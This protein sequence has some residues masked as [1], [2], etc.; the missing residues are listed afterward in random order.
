MRRVIVLIVLI[1][2]GLGLWN[3][4]REYGP[5]FNLG[6]NKSSP[7]LGDTSKVKVVT[8]ESVTVDAV[9]K[10]GPSVVTIAA[11]IAPQSG[12]SPLD[13]G[14]FRIF[15]IQPPDQS[16][17]PV[18]QPQSIGSGFIVSADGLI[19][20]NKHVVSDTSGKYQV[21]TASD[22]KYDVQKI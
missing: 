14:P 8:E 9:K 12:Q 1:L 21:V 4:T 7:T 15:G 17:P 13:L 2:L 19:V 11:T 18:N 20:T 22:K 5:H 6:L 10:V 3:A 16:Q